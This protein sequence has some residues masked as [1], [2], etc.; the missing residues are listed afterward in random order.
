MAHPGSGALPHQAPALGI[1]SNSVAATQ[2]SVAR[3][4]SRIRLR[5]ALSAERS[6]LSRLGGDGVLAGFFLP[7][8]LR[9][10]MCT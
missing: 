3:A 10:A 1:E 6:S 8:I 7:K 9:K 2:I 5:E 4:P